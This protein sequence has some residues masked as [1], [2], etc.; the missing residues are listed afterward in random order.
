M[1][2]PGSRGRT[3]WDP[4]VRC[5][6]IKYETSYMVFFKG[7]RGITWWMGLS[8]SYAGRQEFWRKALYVFQYMH[9]IMLLVSCGRYRKFPLATWLKTTAMCSSYGS[10]NQTVGSEGRV[11]LP[12]PSGRRHPSASD[13]EPEFRLLS[14]MA[15]SRCLLMW[16]L[17]PGTLWCWAQSWD[18]LPLTSPFLSYSWTSVRWG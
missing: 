1:S 8:L 12:L 7:Q 9:V 10:R 4:L 5:Y 3:I 16:D 18:G 13:S 11:V 2:T 14:Q 15:T 17:G 6:L